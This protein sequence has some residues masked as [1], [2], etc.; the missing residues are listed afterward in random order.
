MARDGLLPPLA[1]RVHQRFRTPYVTTILTGIVVSILA[2]LLP[3]GPVGELVSIG[4]LFAFAVVC[5]GVLVLRVMQPDLKRPFKAP[6]VP[7]IA[8]LGCTAARF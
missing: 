8:P 7:I 2:E 3:I 6:A 5:L 4:T 1:A